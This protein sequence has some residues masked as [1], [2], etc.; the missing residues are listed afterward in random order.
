MRSPTAVTSSMTNAP[1]GRRIFPLVLAA[2]SLFLA[3]IL[4]SFPTRN[5][6]FWS[7]LATGRLIAKGDYHFGTDPFAYTTEGVYWANH[8]W[9]F[10]LLLY[11]A[12]SS[13]GNGVVIIKAAFVVGVAVV[14]FSCRRAGH[15]LALPA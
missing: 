2:Q 12:Y 7:Q 11:T 1:V 9:L 14:M 15:G 3:F 5:A 10:D 8:A 13:F 6:D 4:A